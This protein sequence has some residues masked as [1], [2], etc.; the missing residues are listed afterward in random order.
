MAK[1]YLNETLN[2]KDERI[3]EAKNG[4]TRRTL[5]LINKLGDIGNIDVLENVKLGKLDK[6]NHSFIFINKSK[7]KED[8]R[9]LGIF[10]NNRYGY[11]VIEGKEIYTASS[12]GGP[13]NSESKFGI[14]TLG[15]II[16]V[17]TYKNRRAPSYYK[18]TKEGWKYIGEYLESK[19]ED[20]IDNRVL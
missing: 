13:G 12:Y 7:N 9:I 11:E 20:E 3:W 10:L 1:V 4:A 15:T 6:G 5:L 17:N 19:I 16:R 2:F 8:K 18:L 14:Y